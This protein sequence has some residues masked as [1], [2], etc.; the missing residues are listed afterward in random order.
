MRRRHADVVIA[1]SDNRT[2]VH[3]RLRR[4]GVV[5]PSKTVRLRCGRV[6]WR[7]IAESVED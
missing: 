2:H 5:R 4:P 6:K 1:K 3:C 7:T